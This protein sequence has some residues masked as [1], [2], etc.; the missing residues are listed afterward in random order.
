ML[1]GAAYAQSAG[2]AQV[3]RHVLDSSDVVLQTRTDRVVPG[4]PDPL[5]PPTAPPSQLTK[6]LQLRAGRMDLRQVTLR[7]I[8]LYGATAEIVIRPKDVASYAAS[9][10]ANN[11]AL[12]GDLGRNQHPYLLTVMGPGREPQLVVGYV[13]LGPD[14]GAE[15]GWVAPGLHTDAALGSAQIPPFVTC[16][17]DASLDADSAG[18]P[19]DGRDLSLVCNEK[20]ASGAIHWPAPTPA[21]AEWTAC[22][23]DWGGIDLFPTGDAAVCSRLGL[24][25]L[26]QDYSPP[27]SG[28]PPSPSG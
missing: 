13:P 11:A 7:W 21:P 16:F 6:E 15:I 1:A 9:A 8:P 3:T 28:S 22:V 24:Q 26:P 17:Q 27:A 10:S 5:E 2:L 19:L 20:W 4:G 12:L 18:Y 23:A 14:T 25:T